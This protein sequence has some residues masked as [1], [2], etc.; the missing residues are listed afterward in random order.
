MTAQTIRTRLTR[1]QRQY[2]RVVARPRISGDLVEAIRR[3]FDAAKREAEKADLA[4]ENALFALVRR[5]EAA[6]AAHLH[7]RGYR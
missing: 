1:C 2:R 4:E 5:H 3:Q 6:T 7:A